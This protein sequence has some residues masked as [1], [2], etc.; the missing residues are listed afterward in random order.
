[1]KG[2]RVVNVQWRKLGKAEQPKKTTSLTYMKFTFHINGRICS[3]VRLCMRPGGR[4]LTSGHSKRALYVI[5]KRA[6]NSK[7]NLWIDGEVPLESN[8]MKE[9]ISQIPLTKQE[10]EGK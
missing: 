4:I 3:G 8:R 1:M 10:G 6:R 2:K 9:E 5:L 7:P